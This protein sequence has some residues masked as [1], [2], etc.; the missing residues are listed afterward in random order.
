MKTVPCAN[1]SAF[2]VGVCILAWI[3]FAWFYSERPY[4]GLW[5]VSLLM[6]SPLVLMPA[7]EEI[8]RGARMRRRR[9]LPHV[10][11]SLLLAASLLRPACPMAA[12]LATPWMVLRLCVAAE[13]V[14]KWRFLPVKTSGQVC[15]D[16]ASIFPFVGAVWLVAHRANWT[17]WNFDPLIVL[18]TAAHF[19]HAGFTLPL[20]AGLNAK[21]KPGCWT[22]FSCVAI[23]AGVPLVAVGITCT[24]FGV[25]PFVEPVGVAVLVVGATGVAISQL[26][27]GLEKEFGRLVRLGFAVSGVSL[28]VAMLLALGF[29]LR[30]VIPGWA[31]TMPQMWMIHGTLN[32]FGFGLCG[33]LAWRG[34]SR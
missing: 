32:A 16:F 33:I 25:L 29:G 14:L 28:L 24:H 22:R 8:T 19:H 26:R 21:A 2:E 27:R 15:A 5:I 12:V 13:V 17:P 6:L 10:G 9:W 4:D 3:L 31:L 34:T 18:L 20:M 7:G 11:A 30:Y 1:H 23:L